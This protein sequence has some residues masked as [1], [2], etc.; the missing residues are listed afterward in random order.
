MSDIGRMHQVL[1]ITHLPQI[2]A[3]ADRHFLITKRTEEQKTITSVMPLAEAGQV[4]ELSRLMSGGKAKEASATAAQEL[5]AWAKG[6]KLEQEAL[7]IN[8][9]LDKRQ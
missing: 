5:K 9:M 8:P 3:M 4:E 1:C 2:A 6:Y 7:Q